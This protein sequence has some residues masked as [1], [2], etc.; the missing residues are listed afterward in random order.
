MSSDSQTGINLANMFQEDLL[1]ALSKLSEKVDVPELA[2]KNPYSK[3][4]GPIRNAVMNA[5]S[6]M[7][8]FRELVDHRK[9]FHD[10]VEKLDRSINSFNRTSTYLAVSI[11]LLTVISVLLMIFNI[12]HGIAAVPAG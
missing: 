2:V 4:A 3:E 5:M 9:S 10:D 8:V 7:L 11:L 1:D 12:L 6:S